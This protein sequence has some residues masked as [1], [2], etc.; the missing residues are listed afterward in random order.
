MLIR[1]NLGGLSGLVLFVMLI[2]GSVAAQ[3][4]GIGREHAE[5]SRLR[6]AD[7][8]LANQTIKVE[9][10]AVDARAAGI[11][12]RMRKLVVDRMIGVNKNLREVSRDPY[13]LVTVSITRYDYD[14]RTENKKKLMV[15][16]QGKFKIIT[17]GLE[18]SYN[19][20]R[21]AGN[22]T[23]WG[24]DVPANFKNEY[25]EGVETAPIK[26]EV[27]NA[28]IRNAVS[29]I[30]VKLTNTEEKFKVRLMGKNELSRFARLAQ[31]RQ[32]AEYI[33]SI[34]SLPEQ[35]VDEK[36]ESDF[37]GDRHYDL[38]IAHEARF[39][40]TMW[41][42]YKRAQQYFELADSSLRAARKYDP[43]ESEYIKAQARLGQA[44]QYFETIKERFPKDVEPE[45]PIGTP[46]PPPPSEGMINKDVI[47]MVNAGVS[48]R[49]IIEQINEAKLKNFDTSPKGIIQL[50]T[51]GVSEKI[52]DTIKSAMKRQPNTQPPGRKRP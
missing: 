14:E 12:E 11:T 6:P 44:K 2:A 3:I 37:E 7:V 9:V 47:D 52:I 40:E 29:A 16:D 23:L 49:H 18:V 43:R 25:Q 50:T 39:Y 5:L 17:A 13:Y 15:K 36:G 46:P 48:E 4:P 20:V 30:L 21:V 41:K 38:S 32:W 35:K 1:P 10:N 24:G 22:V 33:D 28:L 34:T 26:A 45:R 31:A 42:D 51:A 8:H 19:V 27:E